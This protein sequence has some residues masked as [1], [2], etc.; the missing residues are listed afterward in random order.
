MAYELWEIDDQA[1]SCVNCLNG[2]HI[3]CL[4]F[5]WSEK[6]G[7]IKCGCRNPKH[8]VDTELV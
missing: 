4:D 6:Y 1:P 7:L 5:V 3:G 2:D 8:Q